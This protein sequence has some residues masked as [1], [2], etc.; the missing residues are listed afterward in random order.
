ME[1]KSHN[2]YFYLNY[3]VFLFLLSCNENEKDINLGNNFYYIPFQEIIFD[4]TAFGGNG[5]YQCK[6]N[7]KIPV[8]LPDIEE[9]KYNSEF[10]IAKQN[11]NFEEST[12]LIE[13]M[14]FMPKLY[15]TYNKKFINLNENFLEKLDKTEQ[16][17]IYSEKF[18]IGLLKNTSVFEKMRINKENYYI[19]EKKALKIYGPLSISE[20]KKTKQNLNINL[21]FD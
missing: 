2:K 16:N 5:I 6:N 11:F 10:I 4:V 20:F 21:N 19:I 8:I 9:Y 7:E 17:S 1:R 12:R 14:L 18:T 3:F 13:N 15:F